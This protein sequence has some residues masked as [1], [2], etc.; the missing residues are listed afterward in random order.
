MNAW[1]LYMQPPPWDGLSPRRVPVDAV[2]SGLLFD[3]ALNLCSL[4]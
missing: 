1:L 2:V 3:P 4:Q